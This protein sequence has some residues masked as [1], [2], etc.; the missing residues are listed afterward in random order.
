M[1][2]NLAAAQGHAGAGS[3]RQAA[4]AEMDQNQ[5]MEAQR[6]AVENVKSK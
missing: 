5:L 1:W 6:L 3:M 4:A 2:F